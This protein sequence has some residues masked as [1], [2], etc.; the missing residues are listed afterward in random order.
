MGYYKFGTEKADY[1]F[2]G[3][4]HFWSPIK[5]KLFEGV[6]SLITESRFQGD[7][8]VPIDSKEERTIC[9]CGRLGNG[10][11]IRK[12]RKSSLPFFNLEVV[13][14]WN[15]YVEHRGDKT[16]EQ[17]MREGHRNYNWELA[18]KGIR[19][20]NIKTM[21]YF[22]R[23]S[24]TSGKISDKAITHYT[25]LSM[26]HKLPLSAGRSAIVAEKIEESLITYLQRILKK[27]RPRIAMIYGIRHLDMVN[28]LKNK[29]LRKEIIDFYQERDYQP[30]I[31]SSLDSL[32]EY[33]F[34]DDKEE[35]HWKIHQSRISFQRKTGKGVPI[36]GKGKKRKKGKGKRKK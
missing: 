31:R 11:L 12:L 18:V 25:G 21:Y 1:T 32:L 23:Y 27:E 36:K 35:P 8:V 9:I 15:Q 30:F 20:W 22:H 2:I 24:L 14:D 5:K 4:N 10:S 16:P 28:F 34:V 17:I 7:T 29:E 26:R 33:A 3:V 19:D 13:M 6:D